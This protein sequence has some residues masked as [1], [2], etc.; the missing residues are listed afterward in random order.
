MATK[1]KK[2]KED[3]HMMPNGK[4]MKNHEMKEKKIKRKMKEC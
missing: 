1:K 3:Y 4:M 2:D